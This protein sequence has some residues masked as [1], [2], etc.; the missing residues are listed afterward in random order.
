MLSLSSWRTN[1]NFDPDSI[2]LYETTNNLIQQYDVGVVS[3]IESFNPLIGLD[4]TLQNSLSIRAEYKKTRNLAVSFVNNQMTEVAGSEV[5]VGLGF[6][7]KNLK[8]S[9]GSFDG[10]GKNK[11]YRSDMNLKLDFGIRDN[12]TTLRRID[13]NN[14]Q[15]SAGSRQYT[16][17]LS[18]DYMLSQSLQIRAYYN[19][20]SSNPYVSSQFPTSTTSAGFSVRFNLAQ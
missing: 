19:W 7:V 4:M 17:N 6:R 20:T 1:V 5:V 12:I 18:A 3:L 11:S 10:K 15:V 2:Q 9:V 13:E 8:F 16:L 14:S